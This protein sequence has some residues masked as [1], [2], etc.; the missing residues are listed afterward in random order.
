MLELMKRPGIAYAMT[1]RNQRGARRDLPV[2]VS[3]PILIVDNDRGIGTALTFMLAARGYDEV[4]AVRSA[5][6]AV[7]LAETYR[8]SLVFLD[9]E[10]P[11]EGAL[12]V[13]DQLRRGSQTR[14]L[15]LIALTSDAEHENRETERLAGFERYLVK[16]PSQSELDK[17]LRIRE[18]QVPPPV[19]VP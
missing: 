12:E 7:A 10:L 1:H 15:R 3:T 18:A 14:T 5:R 13:A 17:V 11:D 16:P 9:L 8:P 2:E 19:D 6:R 4:R